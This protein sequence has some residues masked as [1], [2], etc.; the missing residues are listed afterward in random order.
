VLAFD[1]GDVTCVVNF[2]P[3]T[4]DLPPGRVEIASDAVDTSLPPNTAAWIR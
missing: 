2:G 4:V 1:R 3:A